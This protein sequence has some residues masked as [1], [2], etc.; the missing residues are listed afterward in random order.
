MRA[1]P[2]RSVDD[3]A[4]EHGSEQAGVRVCVSMLDDEATFAMLE[5]RLK[6]FSDEH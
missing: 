2:S 6:R 5:E 1:D 3:I 4:A